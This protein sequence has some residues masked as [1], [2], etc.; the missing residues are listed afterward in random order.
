MSGAIGADAIIGPAVVT[1]KPLSNLKNT[2][3]GM[4]GDKF[5]Q[6]S[7]FERGFNACSI[8]LSKRHEAITTASQSETTP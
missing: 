5:T 3:S 4:L 2:G 6:S 8:L 7:D 1:V